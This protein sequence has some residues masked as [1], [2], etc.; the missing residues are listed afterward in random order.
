MSRRFILFAVSSVFAVCAFSMIDTFETSDEHFW[1]DSRVPQFW[2][3]LRDG[4]WAATY[5]NDKPG[6]SV[7]LVS[8]SGLLFLDDGA[9]IVTQNIALRAPLVLV[10][11]F[12]LLPL[13]YWLLLKIVPVFAARMSIIGIATMPLIVGMSQIINPDALLWSTATIAFFAFIAALKAEHFWSR[14][15]VLAG[16]FLGCALL[17]KYTAGLVLIF[18]VLIFAARAL[19]AAHALRRDEMRHAF[20][21]FAVM[22]SLGAVTF[23]VL[24][25]A[26]WGRPDLFLEGTLLSP[27]LGAVA[28][29][30]MCVIVA[31]FVDAFV[32]GARLTTTLTH[33]VWSWRHILARLA[34][35]PLFA[36]LL[37]TVINAQMMT[38][39]VPLDHVKEVVDT[40]DGLAFTWFEGD[41]AGVYFAKEVV[42]QGY[43][44]L[45]SL[46]TVTLALLG[47]A[48][49]Y[50]GCT[51]GWT[52]RE[53]APLVVFGATVPFVFFVGGLVADV[54]VTARYAILLQ[55]LLVLVAALGVH[56]ALSHTGHA[57]KYGVPILLVFFL[58]STLVLV[59]SLPYPFVYQN[60]F[61]PQERLVTDA[62]GYGSVEAA[63]W[64]NTLPNAQ[65]L[66]VWSDRKGVCYYFVGNCIMTRKMT[67]DE[68]PD[69]FVFTR[70][71]VIA[72]KYFGWRT[73]AA[74]TYPPEAYYVPDVL[75]QPVWRHVIHDRPQNYTIIINRAQAERILSTLPY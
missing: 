38:P 1:R 47:L 4:D 30:L 69:Y 9:S 71:N 55:P 58:V 26:L 72:E 14:Y 56:D 63:T 32:F 52:Q 12:V 29:P 33:V 15:S 8:G 43:N 34:L 35:V 2:D 6:V 51:R 60:A 62:W 49:L 42:V 25:P 67:P 11:V 22:S 24:W 73:P 50:F 18:A 19:F 21:V 41:A 28:V 16:V 48:L 27:A 3:A 66:T 53:Y 37:F 44:T 31:W 23:F 20:G 57:R 61:L 13:M 64:L 10:H 54:F 17:A 39:I 70:R 5:I 59:R 36:L 7:A 74:M 45:F 65:E 75:A 68:A 46:P 40:S